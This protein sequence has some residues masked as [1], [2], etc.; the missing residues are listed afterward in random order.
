MTDHKLDQADFFD[1]LVIM[2]ARHGEKFFGWLPQGLDPQSY[3]EQQIRE[4]KPVLLED[5]RVLASQLQTRDDGSGN[6]MLNNMMLL[7]PIDTFR[8]GI[9]KLW[10]YP[11]T[12]YF[13]KDNEKCQA[14]IRRLYE[15]ARKMELAK[16]AADM[17]L[18]I[19][20]LKTRLP[21]PPGGRT[22]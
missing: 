5:A 6:M 15:M 19:P 4:G 21:P 17:N 18:V 8:E 7:M 1:C 12:W 3:I 11:S 20:G 14:G 16:V 22:H 13:P 2:S 9:H 10:V